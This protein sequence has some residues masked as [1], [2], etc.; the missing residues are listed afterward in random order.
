MRVALESQDG[1]ISYASTTFYI[2]SSEW[3]AVNATFS[4]LESDKNA[5]LGIAFQ[6]PG[7]VIVPSTR[8]GHVR[9]SAI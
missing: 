3:K 8:F 4:P 2:G 6:G 9:S 5:R 7:A 1:R